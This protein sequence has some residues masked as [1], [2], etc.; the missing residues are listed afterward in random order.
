[1]INRN[2]R[3]FLGQGLMERNMAW[4]WFAQLDTKQFFLTQQVHKETWVD[5]AV[6]LWG[7]IS[8]A[9]VTSRVKHTRASNTNTSIYFFLRFHLLTQGCLEGV[10]RVEQLQHLQDNKTREIRT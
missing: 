1:M 8:C 10:K 4:S 3:K 7:S 9:G 6:K 2:A 5:L